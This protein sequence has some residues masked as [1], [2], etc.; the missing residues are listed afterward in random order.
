[1]PT[2]PQSTT[3][4]YSRRWRFRECAMPAFLQ[5]LPDRSGVS[6]RMSLEPDPKTYPFP[7]GR[8]DEKGGHILEQE[9]L[10]PRLT[11]PH[12]RLL[13]DRF[14]LPKHGKKEELRSRLIQY[15]NNPA[16]WVAGKVRSH[17]GPR[18]ETRKEK[19]YQRIA[20]EYRAKRELMGETKG[21]GAVEVSPATR[22]LPA[23]EWAAL[24]GAE[25]AAEL[26]PHQSSQGV[27]GADKTANPFAEFIQGHGEK[28]E[29]RLQHSLPP[30]HP[31][32]GSMLRPQEPRSSERE[33]GERAPRSAPPPG[34][35]WVGP[36]SINGRT[37]PFQD[38]PYAGKGTPAARTPGP[39]WGGAQ[40]FRPTNGRTPAHN[41]G[42]NMWEETPKY[43]LPPGSVWNGPLCDWTAPQ[44]SF[45]PAFILP[46]NSAQYPQAYL[47]TA[48]QYFGAP[49]QHPEER[50]PMQ[51]GQQP[52]D[53]NPP[54]TS[55]RTASS[56]NQVPSQ[57]P[58]RTRRPTTLHLKDGTV[59]ITEADLP[60]LNALPVIKIT[61]DIRTALA[62]VVTWWDD[63]QQDWLPTEAKLFVTKKG[64]TWPIPFSRFDE[65]PWPT[66][67]WDYLKK[68]HNELKLLMQHY[69]S[70][71]DK[72]VFFRLV[73]DDTARPDLK[74]PPATLSYTRAVAALRNIRKDSQND[75]VAFL[76][77]DPDFVKKIS[78]KRGSSEAVMVNPAAICKRL[79]KA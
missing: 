38:P 34:A 36:P 46:T 6:L 20:R 18:P 47:L 51:M 40:P 24:V 41:L 70:F 30:F 3:T 39:A 10:D 7:S 43:A 55:S 5:G 19:L 66:K 75:A 37:F 54:F 45:H 52:T 76:G 4:E 72:E 77:N 65:L 53:R 14:Q 12:Y 33:G 78:Y 35:A 68:R 23:R 64:V 63:R 61:G 28:P 29:E 74:G 27:C 31:V 57:T 48:G 79:R 58:A 56:E 73:Y 50:M 69:Y 17:L 2:I 44:H 26:Y 71:E 32:D 8:F 13:C 67:V 21:G 59:T 1:M 9:N 49:S 42:Q 62:K 15:S 60:G 25:I 22:E 16:E 11:V